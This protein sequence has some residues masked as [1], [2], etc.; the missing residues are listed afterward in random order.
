MKKGFL[1]YL[2]LTIE[3][4]LFAQSYKVDTIMYNGPECIQ[5]VILGDGY[6]E[7]ELGKFEEDAIELSDKFLQDF[8]WKDYK[9]FFNVYFI[10]TASNVSGAGL[11]PDT[12][13][14]NFF[15]S[16]YG[17][18][19]ID[20]LLVPNYGIV[21]TLLRQT[22]PDYDFPIVIV[23]HDK[24]GGCGG[25]VICVSN[26]SQAFDNIVSHEAG[27]SIGRLADEY[28]YNGYESP[29][30]T[31][32]SDPEKVKWRN[33]IGLG[34]I[35]IYPYEENP[36]WYRPHQNCRMRRNGA[37]FCAVCRQ[38]LIRSIQQ[39]TNSVTDYYPKDE[40]VSSFRMPHNIEMSRTEAIK[41]EMAAIE[42]FV[43]GNG[44]Y[45]FGL[46]LIYTIPN[47]INVSWFL[48]GKELDNHNSKLELDMNTI[49]AGESHTLLAIVEDETPYIKNDTRYYN[50]QD[51]IWNCVGWKIVKDNTETPIKSIINKPFEDDQLFYY[52]L[53][54]QRIENPGKG[55]YIKNGKKII[56]E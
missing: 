5:M 20:R 32:E 39:F 24:Y 51:A 54:G 16:T 12:P 40:G 46:N 19:G 6:T 31:Q 11:T 4:G 35:G 8:P 10:K 38:A 29:N 33:W 18:N 34:E 30:M 26:N 44:L 9:N 53:Q 3:N 55:L 17:N 28:W 7:S 47:T 52:N 37:P 2:L 45:E 41:K 36:S 13:I 27:H 56:I 21:Y 14:D 43:C 15:Q 49:S 23:N 42:P 1:F 48:D 25:T 50:E 22:V